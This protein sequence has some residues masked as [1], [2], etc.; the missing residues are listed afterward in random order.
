VLE[1]VKVEAEH[2][3]PAAG[4]SLLLAPW[5]FITKRIVE[6]AESG[7]AAAGW[8][9]LTKRLEVAPHAS[10]V[11]HERWIHTMQRAG[12]VVQ[13]VRASPTVGC[14]SPHGN[15]ALELSYQRESVGGRWCYY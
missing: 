1:I 14:E 9:R 4:T 11:E 13:L 6:P 2:F 15:S 3:I 7:C 12:L 10:V 8:Q 5:T